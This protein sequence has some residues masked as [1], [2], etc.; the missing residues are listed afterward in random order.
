MPVRRGRHFLQIPQADE[1]PIAAT[2]PCECGAD[3]SSGRPGRGRGRAARRRRLQLP[4]SDSRGDGAH[5]APRGTRARRGVSLIAPRDNGRQ[6]R[7][8]RCA[9]SSRPGRRT[10]R[11]SRGSRGPSSRRGGPAGPGGGG[12][13][14]R[15]VDQ[16]LERESRA[17]HRTR[18][19]SLENGE[20]ASTDRGPASAVTSAAVRTVSSAEYSWSIDDHAR[21]TSFPGTSA[22]SS[23]KKTSAPSGATRRSSRLSVS[24]RSIQ[25]K[26]R[27]MVTVWNVPHAGPSVSELPSR[28]STA[29]PALA[30]C[31][32]G[33]GEHRG[34]RIPPRGPTRRTARRRWP[35]APAPSP[36]RGGGARG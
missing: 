6:S 2:S 30:G 17:L 35:A 3:S 19:S 25:W 33:D 18:W 22:I 15:P 31:L 8:T 14:Q 34:L 23:L 1:R 24:A 9:P 20:A 13:Q 12:H 16:R 5:R 28:T 32:G 27:P 29:P 7:S 36:G 21:T 26:D 11:A 10:A 4:A